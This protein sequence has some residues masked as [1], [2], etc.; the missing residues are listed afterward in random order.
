MEMYNNINYSKHILF[1]YLEIYV[2]RIN[3]VSLTMACIIRFDLITHLKI[4]LNN[5]LN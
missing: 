5:Y 4:I 1:A 3:I 2:Y